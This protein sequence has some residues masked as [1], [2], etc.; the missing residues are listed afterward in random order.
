MNNTE[1]AFTLIELMVV[2]GIIGILSILAVTSYQD[3]IK[4]ARV[5][6][7]MEMYH[8][9]KLITN[10]HYSYYGVLPPTI[11]SLES[12][13]ALLNGL[14]ANIH[15]YT[16]G[17]SAGTINWDIPSVEQDKVLQFTWNDQAGTWQ[18]D[19]IGTTFQ[20]KYIPKICQ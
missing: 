16:T 6:D 2:I 19:K 14:Y 1:K 18:C 13:G 3:Y 10:E 7:V 9:V 12:F 15:G 17:N 8:S 4:R 5:S 20:D 11:N